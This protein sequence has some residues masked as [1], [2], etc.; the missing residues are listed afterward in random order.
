VGEMKGDKPRKVFTIDVGK[1][2][3]KEAKQ[4][5]TDIKRKMKKINNK[6]IEPTWRG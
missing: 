3:K 4:L 5:V 1:L 6:P 2:S